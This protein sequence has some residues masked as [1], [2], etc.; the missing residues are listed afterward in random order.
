MPTM[1]SVPSGVISPTMA[2]TFEV[3]MSNPTIISLSFVAISRL[4]SPPRHYCDGCRIFYFLNRAPSIDRPI[5][6]VAQLLQHRAAQ[7]A[8]LPPLLFLTAN[9]RAGF[10]LVG[11][12]LVLGRA[13]PAARR[14]KLP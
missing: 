11:V 2:T 5:Q 14:Y 1:F 6:I 7:K 10:A 4:T 3:P 8:Q 12:L 9:Y 13:T